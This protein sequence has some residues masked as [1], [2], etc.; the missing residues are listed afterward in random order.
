MLTVYD[1]LRKPLITEKSNHQN[2]AFNQYAFVVDVRANKTQIKEA[3]KELFGVD[4]VKI[5][6]SRMP[7]KRTRS[8]VTRKTVVRKP[9]YKK[10]LVWLAEGQTIAEFEGVK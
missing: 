6:T 2:G 7:A 1:V 3:L 5:T 8:R 9:E 4:A 10:A